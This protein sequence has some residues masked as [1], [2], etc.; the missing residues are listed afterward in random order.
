[1]AMAIDTRLKKYTY[2]DKPTKKSRSLPFCLPHRTPKS[3]YRRRL[4]ITQSSEC[5]ETG[6]TQC[7]NCSRTSYSLSC[8]DSFFLEVFLDDPFPYPTS[9]G[10]VRAELN[11]TVSSVPIISSWF[12]CALLS[13]GFT[14][15]LYYFKTYNVWCFWLITGDEF[16]VNPLDTIMLMNLLKWN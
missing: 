16:V 6:E 7:L 3:I 14:T 10:P 12:I 2:I 9:S 1:M 8:H 13:S 11:N 4:T 15:F 5:P